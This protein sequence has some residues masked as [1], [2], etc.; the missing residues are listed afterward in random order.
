[1]A[2]RALVLIL[3]GLL[4]AGCA[5]GRGMT[6]FKHPTTGE[7]KTCEWTDPPSIWIEMFCI[8]CYYAQKDAYPRCK[9]GLEAKGYT[10][11]EAVPK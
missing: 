4:M 11:I 3:A 2:M 8:P 5:S 7:I 6:T 10:L 1:M 9:N